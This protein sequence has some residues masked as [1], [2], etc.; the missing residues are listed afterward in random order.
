MNARAFLA[1][2]LAGASAAS[3][4]DLPRAEAAGMV[5][6]SCHQAGRIVYR[7]DFPADAPAEKR[8]L[9]AAR[10][11]G[12]MCV[13]LDVPAEGESAPSLPADAYRKPDVAD[14][15]DPGDPD[16]AAALSVIA[17]GRVGERYPSEIAEA[18]RGQAQPS[19][20][21]PARTGGKD[22]PNAGGFLNLT[23]GIYRNVPMKDVMDHW[24]AMQEDTKVL[25][26]MTPTVNAMDGVIVVS[27][28]SVPDALAAPLC[29]EAAMKGS[30]CVAVY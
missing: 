22:G 21:N 5:R 28:E 4:L 17:E 27:V 16:L 6:A 24:K 20:G 23:V 13:F 15:F 2:V 19:G 30:G 1:A 18:V 29:E 26:R 9:I 11:P 10:H 3:C 25:S 7:E 8:I 12:A 14:S